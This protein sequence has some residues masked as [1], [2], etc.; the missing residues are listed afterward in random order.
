MSNEIFNNDDP[1]EVEQEE[2]KTNWKF[3]CIFSAIYCAIAVG[4]SFIVSAI[5]Q[6]FRY[7]E[8]ISALFGVLALL[9]MMIRIWFR[10]SHNLKKDDRS[11]FEDKQSLSY[12]NWFRMQMCLLCVG[13]FLVLLSQL[14][15][16]IFVYGTN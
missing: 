4:V 10:G 5:V 12:K 2:Q 11:V 16:F 13:L 3:I 6:D 9:F 15:F 1:I 8:I 14:F 7:T